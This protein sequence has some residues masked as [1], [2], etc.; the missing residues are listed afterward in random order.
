[1]D[2]RS[3][4]RRPQYKD[5]ELLIDQ[6]FITHS[7]SALGV[8]L[9]FRSLFPQEIRDI[10]SNTYNKGVSI[11]RL[12]VITKSLYSIGGMTIENNMLLYEVVRRF[13][14]RLR[15]NLFYRVI[16]LM[17]RYQRSMEL[18]QAYAYEPYGDT[19]GIQM[20]VRYLQTLSI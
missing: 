4:D 5:V 1:M 11:Y 7:V 18:A 15:T 12:W 3:L 17:N 14:K 13:P 8:N 9:T 20:G 6:G 16:G 2:Q 10:T 19:L